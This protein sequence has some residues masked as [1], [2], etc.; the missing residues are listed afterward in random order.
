MIT[1][2]ATHK[3]HTRIQ[4]E[5]YWGTIASGFTFDGED[6]IDLITL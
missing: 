5:S 2:F 3:S 6:V 1:V 4:L